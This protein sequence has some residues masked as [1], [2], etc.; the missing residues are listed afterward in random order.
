MTKSYQVKVEGFEGPLDLLL[1]LINRYEIDIYDIPVSQITD[2]YMHYIHTMNE[3][4]LDLASEY[5]VMAA[6]LLAMKS[7][8]LLP[9]PTI[10]DAEEAE[11][12]EDPREELM[13]KLI[14]YRKYKQAAEQLKE[15]ELDANRIYTRPP[16]NKDELGDEPP[17]IKPGEASIYDMIQAMGR[18]L[19]RSK[20]TAPQDTK[21]KK[22]EI[23]I[24]MR[25]EEILNQV[26]L[27]KEGTSFYDLFEKKTRPHIVVTFMALLELMKSNEITCVQ[28]KHF[29]DLIVFKMEDAPWS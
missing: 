29:D 8:M 15:K 2:Q 5:L 17:E 20:T 18:L 13:R 25:M 9:N 4:E 26:D 11:M 14:E 28:Q 7:Q 21:I 19:S 23:P 10:D 6:T 22:D 3:L 27:K 12:E 24:Q 1:H 16:M